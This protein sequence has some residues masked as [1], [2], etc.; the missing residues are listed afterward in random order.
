MDQSAGERTG[1]NCLPG[2][3]K[4]KTMPKPPLSNN[5]KHARDASMYVVGEFIKPFCKGWQYLFQK[6]YR[7]DRGSESGD[8]RATFF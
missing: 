1:I 4:A 6:A 2:T 5:P 3:A 8:L 7:S